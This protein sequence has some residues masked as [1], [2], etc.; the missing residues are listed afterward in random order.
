LIFTSNTGYLLP[1]D[2]IW[3]TLFITVVRKAG[4]RDMDQALATITEVLRE[5]QKKG[6]PNGVPVFCLE[7]IHRHVSKMSHKITCFI[8]IG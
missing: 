3:A 4:T 1:Q 7:D 5:E 6:Y 2:S 8:Q